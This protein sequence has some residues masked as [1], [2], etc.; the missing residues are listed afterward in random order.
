MD[1]HTA[2]MRRALELA[3]RGWGRVSPNPLVGA[4]ILAADGE[5]LGEGWHAGPGT[6]HAEVIALRAAGPRARGETLVCTLEPCNRVGRTP[7]C[8]GAVIRAGV[9]RVFVGATDPNLGDGAPGLEELRRAGLDVTS[10]VLGDECRDLNVAFEHHV[11]TGRPFVILK[12]A[13]SLDGRIAAADG[14][15]RWI[16]SPEA[17]ADAHELR[18][19][20]DAIVVGAGT[21]AT[22]DPSL[23]VRDDRFREARPPLRVVVD[24]GG[25]IAPPRRLFDG[26]AP[27]WV[28][29]TERTPGDIL[30]T[31]RDVGAEVVVLDRDGD[32][33]VS[34]GALIEV[35]GKRDVQGLLVE[36]GSRLAWSFVRDD[37]VDRIVLYLAPKV[38]GGDGAAGIVG[39][40]G[41]AP[42]DAARPVTFRR[43]ERIGP[44]L[45]VVADVHRDR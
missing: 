9:A 25:R 23:T 15:A 11:R 18:A 39:G 40:D 21:V 32:D 22:D 37:L 29:T 43:V 5:V 20:S 2:E 45:K 13:A 41:F 1:G 16:T 34:L 24:S 38:L 33:R 14:S 36:G 42:V 12:E 17:R 8:T 7:P 28:V 10:G 27:T 35:L 19:W 4:V 44:D 30:E 26:S 31:W 6:E 3:T